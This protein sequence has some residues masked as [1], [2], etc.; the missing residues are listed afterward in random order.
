[1]VRPSRERL[2]QL[3]TELVAAL[4]RSHAVV[5]LKDRCVVEQAVMQVLSDE[6]KREEEREANVRRRIAEMKDG[7]EPDTPEWE[8]LFRRLIEEEHV[9]DGLDS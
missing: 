2:E 1:M 4:S 9:R 6:L 5:L 8:E 7:P 3:A